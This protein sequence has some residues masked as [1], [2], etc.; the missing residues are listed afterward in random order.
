MLASALYS[1][2]IA[3][4]EQFASKLHAQLEAALLQYLVTSRSLF[5]FFAPAAGSELTLATTPTPDTD[6]VVGAV[7]ALGQLCHGYEVTRNTAAIARLY[8]FLKDKNFAQ[9][10]AAVPASDAAVISACIT[11]YPTVLVRMYRM[12][13]ITADSINTHLGELRQQREHVDTPQQARDALDIA[14]AA[15]LYGLTRE[16][17]AF[18]DTKLPS[19]FARRLLQQLT[20]VGALETRLSTPL[21]ISHLLGSFLL[22]PYPFPSVLPPWQQGL[23]L[24]MLQDATM[25]AHTQELVQALMTRAEARDEDARMGRSCVWVLGALL[26]P[27][28]DISA[29]Q[30]APNSLAHLPETS[31]VRALFDV[32]QHAVLSPVAGGTASRRD[33]GALHVLAHLSNTKRL[34]L[35]N[36]PPLLDRA[37]KAQHITVEMKLDVL[38]LA[39][40]NAHVPPLVSWLLSVMDSTRFD[41]LDTQLKRL[42]LSNLH[43]LLGPALGEAHSKQL[44]RLFLV[45]K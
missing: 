24:L 15:L 41:P 22:A 42:L 10:G 25:A 2:T 3:L 20:G 16:G 11:I 39:I 35:V 40:H 19:D 32:L 30:D 4:Q 29:V 26:S 38:Y 33:E 5:V 43:R 1:G 23:S 28:D 27:H 13:A 31:I 37:L 12:K 44:V 6:G 8:N 45:F 36:W 14:L 17:F 18:A 7:L 9:V 34:P 21:A